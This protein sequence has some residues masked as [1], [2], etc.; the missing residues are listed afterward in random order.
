MYWQN[1]YRNHTDEYLWSHSIQISMSTLIFHFYICIHCNFASMH[2]MNPE[3]FISIFCFGD[4]FK[5]HYKYLLRYLSKNSFFPFLNTYLIRKNSKVVL[6]N[7][8]HATRKWYF[9]FLAITK[10]TLTGLRKVFMQEWQW[11]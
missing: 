5:T 9:F 4:L 2:Y 1:I 8:K 11:L 10:F 7:R 3:I 6:P